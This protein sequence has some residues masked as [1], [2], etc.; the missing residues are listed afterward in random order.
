MSRF[1]IIVLVFVVV[2]TTV[3]WLYVRDSS[4]PSV[5]LDMKGSSYSL[6]NSVDKKVIT[7]ISSPTT[8]KLHDGYY[9]GVATDS[10]YDDT[11]LCFSVFQTDTS[12]TFD[13]DYSSTY[14]QELNSSEQPSANAALKEKYADIIKN[15]TICDGSLYAK[16][17]LYGTAI[18]EKSASLND[19]NDVY[20]VILK[21]E[22]SAWVV[23][24]KPVIVLDKAT[25][26]EIPLDILKKINNLN[27]CKPDGALE[28]SQNT[29]T[30]VN[31]SPTPPPNPTTLW[32]S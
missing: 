11:P 7:E 18:I 13:A 32:P 2:T 29:T 31:N 16:G 12:Y 25:F 30:P 23:I 15:F 4:L 24:N 19:S 20:R 10:K 9:C 14:T 6:Y 1:K 21:K 5:T 17:T 22:G 26:S 27:V 3:G 28:G 8:I